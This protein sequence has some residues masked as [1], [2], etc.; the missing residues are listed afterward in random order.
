MNNYTPIKWSTK[1]NGQRSKNRQSSKPES[2]RK[3]EQT[4]N[5]NEV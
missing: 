3:C 1:K 5:P 4:N 2:G